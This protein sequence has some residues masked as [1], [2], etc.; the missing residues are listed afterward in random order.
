MYDFDFLDYD[1]PASA[2]ASPSSS[3]DQPP[4]LVSSLAVLAEN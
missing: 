1:N 4:F 2:T 3:T